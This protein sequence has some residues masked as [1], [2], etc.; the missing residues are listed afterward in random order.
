M[1]WSNPLAK[2]MWYIL[3]VPSL[4]SANSDPCTDGHAAPNFYSSAHG[5]ARA[6]RHTY[7][8]TDTDASTYSHADASPNCYANT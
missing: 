3:T 6:N 2:R 4:R 8:S 7:S 1:M 5:N